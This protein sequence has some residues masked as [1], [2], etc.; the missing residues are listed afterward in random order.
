MRL[1]LKSFQSSNQLQ[2]WND[3]KTDTSGNK[4]PTAISGSCF[5][6]LESW[7]R[8]IATVQLN[9]QLDRNRTYR[10]TDPHFLSLIPGSVWHI[11]GLLAPEE[12]KYLVH[13]REDH[14]QLTVGNAYLQASV[15]SSVRLGDER[16]DVTH[17]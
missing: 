3:L 6:L 2:L 10:H 8:H 1:S 11:D 4:I 13:L 5:L 17:R 7:E 16:E 14:L 15:L 12:K 9:L